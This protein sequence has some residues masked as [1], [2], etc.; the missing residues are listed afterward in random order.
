MNSLNVIKTRE[1]GLWVSCEV[2]SAACPKDGR[3]IITTDHT[4][5]LV[6]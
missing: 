4:A 5:R 3:S 6:T 2:C 1:V